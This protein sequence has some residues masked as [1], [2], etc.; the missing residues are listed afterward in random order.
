[1]RREPGSG[2]LESKL[3][4]VDT[5]DDEALLVVGVVERTQTAGTATPT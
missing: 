1:M 5:D 2:F 3:G 4:R